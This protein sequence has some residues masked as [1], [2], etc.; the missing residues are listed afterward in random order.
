[1]RLIVL[2]RIPLI[3]IALSLP[4]VFRLVP[5]NGWYGYRTPRSRSSP[6]EW[7]R[8]NRLAGLA[9]VGAAAL[10]FGIKLLLVSLFP[11][12]PHLRY[13]NLVDGLALLVVVAAM[14]VTTE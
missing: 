1:M 6:Q 2:L 4:L 14:L 8:L 11:Q 7:Y 9:V 10:S 13:V 3:L 12:S 5:P